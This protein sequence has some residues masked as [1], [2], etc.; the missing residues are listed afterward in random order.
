MSFS[1]KL[2]NDSNELY[3]FWNIEQYPK[4]NYY[5]FQIW[6]SSFSQVFTVSN[7]ILDTFSKIKP[8]KSITKKDVVPP[9]FVSSGYYKNG[10]IH[11]EIVNK[12]KASALQFNGNLSRTEISDRENINEVVALQGSWNETVVIDSGQLFDIGFSLSTTFSEQQDALYLADGP[13]VI[14]CLEEN[15]QV[16]YFNKKKMYFLKIMS[17]TK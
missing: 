11:L 6:G 5:N 2:G 8:L 4:G 13:W 17:L 12:I 3:S 14:D 9:V 1:V 16:D 7:Y 15:I 10:K